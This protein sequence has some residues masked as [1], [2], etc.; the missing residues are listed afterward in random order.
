MFMVSPCSLATCSGACCRRSSCCGPPSRCRSSS[1]TPCR[2]TRSPWSPAPTPPTSPPEQ[3]DALRAEYGLDRPLVVQ[4]LDQ[5]GDAATATSGGRCR[6]AARSPRSSPRRCRRRCRSPPPASSSP[7][8]AAPR[9]PSPPRTCGRG[10]CA[11]PA[12]QPAAAR[13]RRAVVLGRPGAAATVLVR[14]GWFP[15][16]GNEGWRSIVLPAITLALP[17]GAQIAQLLAK[18]ME[19]T[20]HEPYIDTARAKGASRARVHVR[21]AL[22]NAALPALTMAGLLVGALLVGHRRHRDRVLPQRARPPDRVGRRRPGHPGRPGARAVRR[23]RVRRRQ[24]R[25]RPRLPAARPAHRAAG[26]AAAVGPAAALAGAA[27]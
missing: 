12:A 8:S 5:L 11:R 17:T 22:R 6:A 27:A 9:S 26:P 10:G 7:S 4:Y 24:P 19:T 1:S 25:R 16:V 14:L 23:D 21:H 3:L 2:A 18:S 20:L 15:A 13:R